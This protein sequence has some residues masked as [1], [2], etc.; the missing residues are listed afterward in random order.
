[1]AKWRLASR[2]PGRNEPT[3]RV[4]IDLPWVHRELRR[5]GVTLQQL[6]CEYRDAAAAGPRA[7]TPYGYS[8]FCDL[9]A[10]FRQRADLSV[11]GGFVPSKFDG[12]R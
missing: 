12:R 9:Y 4:T 2:Y 10:D 3:R 5:P 6:W 8:Q 1:M 7:G 11:N